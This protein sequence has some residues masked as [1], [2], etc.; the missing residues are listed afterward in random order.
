[1]QTQS[2]ITLI[3]GDKVNSRTDYRDALPVNMYAVRRPILG[4]DGYMIQQQGLTQ[5][6]T[7]SGIDRGGFWNDRQRLHFRVSG[8]SLITVADDGTVSAIGPISGSDTAVMDCSF[9]TQAICANGKFWLYDS[10][11]GFRQVTDPDLGAPIDFCWVDGYYFFTDGEYIY[12]TDINNEAAIDPLKFATAEFIP[13]YTYGVAKTEDNKV[14][15]FGRYSIEYFVNQATE[16]FAFTRVVSRALKIGIVGTHAKTEVA[17]KYYILG[18]RKEEA[19]SFHR[20][21]VGQTEKL[22]SREI[23][24]IL[25]E[26]SDNQL[27]DV[28]LESFESDGTTFVMIHLPNHVLMFNQTIAAVAGIDQAWSIWKSDVTGSAPCRAKHGVFDKRVN[29]WIFGDKLDS[30]IGQLDSSVATQY[31]AIVEWELYT[32]FLYLEDQSIDE[33]E[34]ETIPGFTS[35]TDA[36]V[37]ISMTYNGITYSNEWVQMYGLPAEYLSRFIVR[38]L[39]YI[40]NWVG[41]KLR[42]ATRSRMAFGRGTIK[43][44]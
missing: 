44:G 8:N 9:N 21:G 11:S 40:D 37:F 34:I 26:Y 23:D 32:P 33:L 31:G 5:F 39:G 20:V 30:T 35:T 36:T 2:L 7:G 19:V 24:Q 6:A 18:N 4:A 22:A 43:H 16:N 42:G 13:D 41:F 14:M 3:K 15:V 38:R 25:Q 17:G 12:H 29:K 1:M 10:T 28:V 27:E